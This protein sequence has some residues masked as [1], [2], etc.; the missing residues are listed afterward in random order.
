MDHRARSVFR[1]G[2]VVL[3]LV[4]AAA[5]TAWAGNRHDVSFTY[6]VSQEPGSSS[7]VHVSLR[8]SLI[9]RG[10]DPVTIQGIML[11]HVRSLEQSKPFSPITVKAHS[12]SQMT[13]ELTLSRPE[14]ERWQKDMGPKIL[15]EVHAAGNPLPEKIHPDKLSLE[16]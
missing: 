1:R 9:N 14:F 11:R 4:L 15:L 16:K 3:A 7:L 2:Q 8:L 10:Q 5:V 12:S 13:Q 6:S